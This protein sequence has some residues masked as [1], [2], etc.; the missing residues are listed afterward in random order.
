MEEVL[1]E[2]EYLSKAS[3]VLKGG[4]KEQVGRN[5]KEGIERE[6]NWRQGLIERINLLKGK[7]TEIVVSIGTVEKPKLR[8]NVFSKLD[9]EEKRHLLGKVTDIFR[10]RDDLEEQYRFMS[11]EETLL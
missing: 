8:I 2:G 7:I 1:V 11:Q 4:Y 10:L 9:A 6:V 3:L 5:N